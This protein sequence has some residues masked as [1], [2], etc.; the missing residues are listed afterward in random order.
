MK[1]R[2]KQR[3]DAHATEL[4]RSLRTPFLRYQFSPHCGENCSG[5]TFIER[6]QAI[7]VR[8]RGERYGS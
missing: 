2:N 4:G 5:L 1:T 6:E 7:I 8:E 3:T